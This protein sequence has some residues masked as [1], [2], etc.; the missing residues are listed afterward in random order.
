MESRFLL[1]PVLGGMRIFELSISSHEQTKKTGA[2]VFLYCTDGSV[3]PDYLYYASLIILFVAF[4]WVVTST[5]PGGF[6]ICVCIY[7]MG[8]PEGSTES[9]F[10]EKLGFEPATP[11]LQDIGLS[12]TPRGLHF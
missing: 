10:M 6:M 2:A 3:F 4:S 9:D 11:G 1:K 7:M 12:P 5:G 8:T